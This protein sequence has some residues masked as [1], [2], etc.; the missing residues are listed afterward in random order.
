MR[1]SSSESRFAARSIH[2][3]PRAPTPAKRPSASAATRSLIEN[4][5]VP[6][7]LTRGAVPWIATNAR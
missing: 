3:K 2:A 4:G 7:T 5:G 1:K 6:V